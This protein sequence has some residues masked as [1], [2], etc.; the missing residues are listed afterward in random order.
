[1]KIARPNLGTGV[2][3]GNG[4][5]EKWSLK[6]YKALFKDSPEPF[7]G[8]ISMKALF[9]STT[10]VGDSVGVQPETI[11][12]PRLLTA[13]AV[14]PIEFFNMIPQ[15][16]ISQNADVYLEEF[17]ITDQADLTVSEGGAYTESSFGLEE[18]SNPIVKVGS[19]IPAT[20][21]VL[22]DEAMAMTYLEDRL[23]AQVMR[24]LDK[25]CLYG[26]GTGGQ[27]TGLTVVT[28]V[29]NIAKTA[30]Q[31][32][33]EALAKA[34]ETILLQG[35]TSVDYIFMHPTDWWKL[36][37]LQSATG[38]FI[39][40]PILN[41]MNLTFAGIPIMPCQALNAGTAVMGAFRDFAHIRDR[42][43]YST[44]WYQQFRVPGTADPTTD[45]YTTPT[46]R[47]ILVGEVRL[48]I[49]FRR[50]KAF[51]QVTNL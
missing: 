15:I 51:A 42:Q 6:A 20:E 12:D 40:G 9:N 16:P 44:N 50:P 33:W 37:T 23:P 43:Q 32:T 41:A 34:V 8:A 13:A 46:G 48:A 1:M 3:D 49:T 39:A 11:R 5:G 21:E 31:N 17:D 4:D 18:K 27:L 45:S 22:M 36:R 47:R 19:Y 25:R 29:H 26:P 24:V 10:G 28:G 7:T 2:A 30:D 38:E 35:Q 14:R